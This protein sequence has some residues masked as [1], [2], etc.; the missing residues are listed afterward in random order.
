[1]HRQGTL[2]EKLQLGPGDGATF[3]YSLERNEGVSMQVSFH[4]GLLCVG[5]PGDWITELV[6]TERIGWDAE[7][8]TG[9]GNTVRVMVEKD[10]PC[11]VTRPGE[12]DSDAFPAS[13][14]VCTAE[15]HAGVSNSTGEPV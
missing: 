1:M 12:D 11:I 15:N 3:R 14:T 2:L 13:G 10:F 6:S 8:D 9:D 5:L 7:L 4:S